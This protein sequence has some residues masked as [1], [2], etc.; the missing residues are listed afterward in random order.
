M[1]GDSFSTD[2]YKEIDILTLQKEYNKT[3]LELVDYKVKNLPI[4]PSFKTTGLED[5]RELYRE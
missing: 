4:E 3:T 1:C 2:I 5:Y